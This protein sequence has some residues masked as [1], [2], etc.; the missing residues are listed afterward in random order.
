MTSHAEPLSQAGTPSTRPAAELPA[1]SGFNEDWLAVCLPPIVKGR[2]LNEPRWADELR[3][4]EGEYEPLLPI[5]RK[6]IRYTFASGIVLLIV[7][8]LL[9]RA[10]V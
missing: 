9:S 1:R 5:E 3:K 7:L 10:F 6:Q 2:D 8:V 4:M